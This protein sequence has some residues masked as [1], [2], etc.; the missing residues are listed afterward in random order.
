MEARAVPQRRRGGGEEETLRALRYTGTIEM[1]GG[2]LKPLVEATQL[3]WPYHGVQR[4]IMG[5]RGS[6]D[7]VAGRVNV[8][9][10]VRAQAQP[11][12]GGAIVRNGDHRIEFNRHFIRPNGHAGSDR[13]AY[14][15]HR[16]KV[17]KV[18]SSKVRRFEGYQLSNLR[19]FE[20]A[21]IERVSPLRLACGCTLCR[22]SR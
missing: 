13:D 5:S 20:L 16:W 18:E 10:R 3:A 7:E 17:R 12:H 21:T 19:T 1:R 14:V 4:K 22:A 15:M 8:R 9:A 11:R 2:N 6:L